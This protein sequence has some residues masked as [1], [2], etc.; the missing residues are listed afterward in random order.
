MRIEFR[1]AA[2]GRWLRSSA[3]TA[4]LA[5]VASNALADDSTSINKSTQ[6]DPAGQV[7]VSNTVG[8]VVGPAGTATRSRSRASSARERSGWSSTTSAAS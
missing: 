4:G 7:E 5:L 2:V 1:D 6:A 8:T 3:L